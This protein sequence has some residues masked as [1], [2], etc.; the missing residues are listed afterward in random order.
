MGDHAIVRSIE[1]QESIERAAE[2][3]QRAVNVAIDSLPGSRYALSGTWLG[4]S[5]HAALTDV[6]VGAWTAGFVLDAMGQA[7]GLYRRRRLQPGADLVCL[8]GLA[9]AGAAAITGLADWSATQA[10][11]KR[12]GFVHGV[13]NAVIACLYAASVYQRSRGRRGAGVWC[14]NVGFGLLLVS[15]W[16]GRELSYTY[17]VGVREPRRRTKGARPVEQGRPSIEGEMPNAS[18]P[19]PEIHVNGNG[20]ASP[21]DTWRQH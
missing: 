17:G 3:L 6:P 1:R 12:V 15:T 11:A 4:H 5:L 7:G 14:S 8:I 9:G 10:G 19:A 2:P 16:L 13:T 18:S 21:S 20:P